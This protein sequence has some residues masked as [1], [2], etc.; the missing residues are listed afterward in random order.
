M[1]TRDSFF[2]YGI[3]MGFNLVLECV[4]TSPIHFLHR[5]TKPA[6]KVACGFLA[7]VAVAPCCQ[8]QL[9]DYLPLNLVPNS[10]TL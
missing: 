10:N 6:R 1:K 8:R 2:D 5:L 9:D 3:I 4:E 7:T